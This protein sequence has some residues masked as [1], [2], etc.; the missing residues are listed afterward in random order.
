M[1][2]DFFI[3][4]NTKRFISSHISSNLSMDLHYDDYAPSRRE[5]DVI[6]LSM[7]ENPFGSSRRATQHIEKNLKKM[8]RYSPISPELVVALA[9]LNRTSTENVIVTDGADGALTLVFLALARKKRVIVPLPAFPRFHYYLTLSGS[10]LVSSRLGPDFKIQ[11]AEIFSKHADVLSLCSPNNPTGIPVTTSFVKDAL[12]RFEL[13]IVDEAM[14]CFGTGVSSLLR[15]YDNLIITRSFSKSFGLAGM[16]IG[17]ALASSKA[18]SKISSFSSPFKTTSLS[19]IAALETLND[20]RYI[21]DSLQK[22]K[23][24]LER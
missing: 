24:Q 2:P 19:Q 13:V 23:S 5:S 21:S 12:R 9:K 14:L 4:E 10:E 8:N 6:D 7:V 17:Y 18:I 3:W 11:D 22:I 1:E 15:D 16:R 20:E